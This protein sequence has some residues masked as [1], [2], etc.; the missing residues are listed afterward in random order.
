MCSFLA[1]W[2]LCSMRALGCLSAAL[3]GSSRGC[4]SRST[5]ATHFMCCCTQPNRH[6]VLRLRNA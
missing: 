4:G 1:I 5:Q 2:V 3:A 6:T